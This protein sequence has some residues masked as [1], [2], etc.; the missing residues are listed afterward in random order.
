MTMPLFIGPVHETLLAS[1]FTFHLSVLKRVDK[2]SVHSFF[3]EF[4][5]SYH[6][7]EEEKNF[8]ESSYDFFRAF[9][10]NWWSIFLVKCFRGLKFSNSV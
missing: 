3:W 8:L 10:T 2:R 1:T 4:I 6:R 7:L 5:S 9:N